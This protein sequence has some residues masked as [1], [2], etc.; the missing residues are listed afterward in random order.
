MPRDHDVTPFDRRAP[1][2]ETGWLGRLHHDIADRAADLALASGPSPRRVLD[3]GCGTGYLL[4]QLAPRA[5]EAVELAGI[6][7]APAMIEAARAMADD[8]RLRFSAGAAEQLPYPDG[9]FDLVMSTTSFDHWADQR[10]GLRECA[11]VMAPG[12]HLVLADQ[13]SALLCVSLLARRRGKA[14][15]KK[16][17]TRLLRAAGLQTVRWQDLYG[18]IIRAATATKA[19]A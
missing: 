14:R 9:T 10:A 16:R 3:V 11:R 19:V 13:F 2:Y 4:R 17:A 12:G 7:P 8:D 1:G 5:P 15:T 6:D 18:V